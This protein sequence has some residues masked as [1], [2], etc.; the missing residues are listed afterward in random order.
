MK[1]I[2]ALTVGFWNV[3]KQLPPFFVE[4]FAAYADEMERVNE[5][6]GRGE[7]PASI[8]KFSEGIIITDEIQKDSAMLQQWHDEDMKA[9][10][11]SFS[12]GQS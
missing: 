8:T 11:E 2:K 5:L 7:Y 6:R 10:R 9:I 12:N 3:C 4:R 1:S